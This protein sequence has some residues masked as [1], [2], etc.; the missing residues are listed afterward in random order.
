MYTDVCTG[1]HRR[2]LLHFRGP[3][4]SSMHCRHLNVRRT[5]RL[6][7]VA[8]RAFP[9]AGPRVWNALPQHVMSCPFTSCF[10]QSPEDISSDTAMRTF[11]CP[12]F[13][14]SDD[15]ILDTL[16]A[17]FTYLVTYSVQCTPLTREKRYPLRLSG[18]TKVTRDVFSSLTTR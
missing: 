2:T 12:E 8:D 13:P 9:V 5:T 10:P 16:I 14:R 3:T 7:I 18:P 11:N 6:S 4:A 1:L 15:A 17:H